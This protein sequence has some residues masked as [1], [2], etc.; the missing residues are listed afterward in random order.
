MVTTK[1][2]S[3]RAAM[4]SLAATGILAADRTAARTD[5][6][7]IELDGVGVNLAG[8]EFGSEKPTFCNVT[9]GLAGRD[10]T[11]PSEPTV[12]YFCSRGL[13]LMRIPFRWERLQPRL[14]QSTAQDELSRLQRL[15]GMAR[16]AGGRVIL[17]LHNYG[18][19]RTFDQSHPVEQV[20]SPTGIPGAKLTI[21]HLVDFWVRLSDVFRDDD[22]VAAYGLM[23]EPH[24]LPAGTWK[25]ASNAAVQAI[26]RRGD[27]KVIL[28]GGD[29]WSSAIRF[30]QVNGPRAWVDDPLRRTAYEA[31]CYFDADQS[32]KYQLS[33]DEEQRL[34]RAIGHRAAR[35]VAP[36]LKWCQQNRVAGFVGEFGV[37]GND[38]R[39]LEL[40]GDFVSVLRAT[41]TAACYWAAG[42]W[43]GDYAL[44][45]QPRGTDGAAAP[46]MSVLTGRQDLGPSD[47]HRGNGN[48]R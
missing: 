16:A 12:Q 48:N 34:D 8:A 14:G 41:H 19:Y 45:I 2:M 1:G 9:P 26:R 44:S 5:T 11:Y 27:R 46:Q 31:H 15:A 35:T 47:D 3:R 40:L 24:G 22:A 23:N 4:G 32:G 33:Y 43:W 29:E 36:F 10:Y 13:S 42:E 28:V 21:A 7:K 6:G 20:L 37:P 38:P 25:T 30:P 17:D 39:W 18:R